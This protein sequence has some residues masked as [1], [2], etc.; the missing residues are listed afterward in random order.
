MERKL[1]KIRKCAKALY[2]IGNLEHMSVYLDSLH[3]GGWI[4]GEELERLET[5]I[6]DECAT[7]TMA[8]LKDLRSKF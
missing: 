4:T 7:V 1:T 8:E 2:L 3:D 5:E 6:T